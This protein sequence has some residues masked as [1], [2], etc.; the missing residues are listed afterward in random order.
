M[1]MNQD[2]PPFDDDEETRRRISTPSVPHSRSGPPPQGPMARPVLPQAD[3]TMPHR[4]LPDEPLPPEPESSGLYVP[5]WG[6]VLVILAVAGITCGLWSVVL[7]NRGGAATSIGPTPTLVFV[8]ITPTATLGAGGPGPLVITS[9]PPAGPTVAPQGG[10]TP[11]APA[12]ATAPAA[13]GATATQGLPIALGVTIQVSGTGGDGLTVRQGP[14]KD[15]SS[16][17]VANEGDKFV[18]KDGPRQ[19]NGFTWWYVVDPADANRF[20]WAVQDFMQVVQ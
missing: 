11:A 13:D 2:Y 7:I 17:F 19:A 10:G 15:F 8:V 18:V 16:V 6:F 1:S 5:W 20:G 3:P 9:T 4:R 12:G 14:G